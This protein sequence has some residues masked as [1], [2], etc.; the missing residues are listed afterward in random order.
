MRRAHREEGGLATVETTLMVVILV[1]LLFGVIE[2][3]SLFQRWLAAETV[4][5]HAARYAGELG[6]DDAAL[7]AFIARELAAVG[8]DASA[9]TVEIDPS[10]VTWREPIR[11][12][13]RSSERIDLPFAFVTP[14]TISATAVAR[15]EVQR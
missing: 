14:I 6:G 12:T 15:G 9:V 3:G 5:A 11:V 1:P 4:A 2:F 13:V 8:I 10:R 7:R